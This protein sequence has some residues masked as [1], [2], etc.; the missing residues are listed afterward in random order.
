M[1]QQRT[2]TIRSRG[3]AQTAGRGCRRAGQGNRPAHP[4][5]CAPRACA[6]HRALVAAR[7]ARSESA[8]RGPD[9]AVATRGR[10]H[11][12]TGEGIRCAC[13]R[14]CGKGRRQCGSCR[15][16]TRRAATGG[17][18]SARRQRAA[19]G[20]S[21]CNGIAQRPRRHSAG[22]SSTGTVIRRRTGNTG[23]RGAGAPAQSTSDRGI[24]SRCRRNP[25]VRPAC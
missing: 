20:G 25:L 3:L 12:G 18:G 15:N 23:N 6:A 21:A 19:A 4:R 10:R 22:C 13:D 11:A 17:A 2:A 7:L 8:A 16:G 14:A 1:Q 5:R 24:R 9:R